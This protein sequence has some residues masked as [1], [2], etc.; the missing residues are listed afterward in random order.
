MKAEKQSFFMSQLPRYQLES[1]LPGKSSQHTCP[2]CNARK[3]FTRYADTKTGELLPEEFGICNNGGKCG[4][5]LSPYHKSPASSQYAGAMS[6]A[7][8]VRQ[9]DQLP[10]HWFTAVSKWQRSGIRRQSAV[11][12]L[13]LKE[14]ATHEQAQAVAAFIYDR[15]INRSTPSP[16]TVATPTPICI[17]PDDV[18]KASLTGYE[19]NNFAGLLFDHFGAEVAREL[20]ARFHIGTSGYW[21]GANVFWFVDEVGRVRGGQV[22]CYGPD[23]HKAKYTDHEGNQ[24]TCISSVSHALLK[25]YRKRGEAAPTWLTDYHENAPR[26]PGCF[27]AHQL[28]NA[29]IDIPVA[30]VEGPATAIFCSAYFPAFI[31]LAVGSLSYLTAERLASVKHRRVTL[32]PDLSP[33]GTAYKIWSQRAETL[34]ADGFSIEVDTFLEEHA[35]DTERTEKYDLRDYLLEQ[36]PGYQSEHSPGPID[37]KSTEEKPV[38]TTLGGTPLKPLT[39]GQQYDVALFNRIFWQDSPRPPLCWDKISA[40]PLRGKWSACSLHNRDFIIRQPI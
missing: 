8:E 17:I 18:F 3:Q 38:S 7:D 4:Y 15:S 35:S 19:R 9:R 6:Y 13:V 10:R 36:W 40:N 34:R 14:G 12:S 21:P 23:H 28:M 37:I 27:G 1:K 33:D 22:V 16:A 30:I 24:K 32:F 11:D 25:R 5:H 2:G 29:P 20:I 39:K 31:W 26:I